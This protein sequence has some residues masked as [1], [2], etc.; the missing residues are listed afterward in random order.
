MSNQ[1]W[2]SPRLVKQVHNSSG[3]FQELNHP[4]HVLVINPAKEHISF[5]FAH[6]PSGSRTHQPS[7]SLTAT[8]STVFGP[9]HEA[10]PYDPTDSGSFVN[11]GNISS[12]DG[13][14]VKLDISP[15]AWSG[16]KAAGTAASVFFYYIPR[17]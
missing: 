3:S 7:G 12:S 16:S 15:I 4:D 1:W 5:K 17:R 2:R 11:M 10:T 6:R 13:T 8:D 9:A 14:P